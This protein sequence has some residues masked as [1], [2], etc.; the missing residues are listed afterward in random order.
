MATNGDTGG[1]VPWLR[2][3]ILPIGSYIVATERI[4]A[5]L[6]ASVS[7]RDRVFFD[8][9][10]FLCY[11]RL[12][13]DGDRVL[14]GGRTSLAPT[15]VAQS[16]DQL[17]QRMVRIHPQLRGARIER[18]WGGKVALTA[19]RLPHLG[20]HP[21]TG[22]VYAMGYCGTGV[23]LSTHFGRLVGR[24][25]SGQEPEGLGP[26]SERPWRRT[27]LPARVPWLLPVG[28]WWYQAQDRRR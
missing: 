21:G 26:Y 18:A 28:G 24:W 25:L 9:R 1:L 8:T 10:N 11:W 27:P 22:V 16:R 7:P 13:P 12:S 6:A 20:R 23:A 17:Y 4:D 15:T 5:D 14:F 2:R 3:R 19:D